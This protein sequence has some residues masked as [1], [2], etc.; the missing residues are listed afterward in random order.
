MLEGLQRFGWEPIF[1][2]DRVI[3]LSRGGTARA[4]QAGDDEQGDQ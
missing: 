1:E 3:S 4:D 2:G